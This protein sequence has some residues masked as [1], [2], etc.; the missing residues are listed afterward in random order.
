MFFLTLLA[1]PVHAATPATQPADPATIKLLI[2]TG[3]HTFSPTF[4]KQFDDMPGV[5]CTRAE[6]GDFKKGTA[7]AYDLAD[8]LSYDAVLLYDFQLNI[9]PDE[10]KHFLALF[11]KG[12]G[13]IVLHHALLS[14]QG[15]PEY[16]R[17]TGGLYLLDF[18]KYG[19]VLVPQSTYK[20]ETEMAITVVDK[21]HPVT[22]GVSDFHIT[23]EI[24]RGVHHPDDIHT[25]L[26]CEGNPLVWTRDE[27]NS[28]VV[29][30]IIGH[31]PGTW[32]NAS[33]Q[34]LLSNALHFVAKK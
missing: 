11:D 7:S 4:F 23:D 5:T 3:G 27:K 33:F 21:S 13:L 24:Y 10:Q 14:Y 12:T 15:W 20:G 16:E 29:S 17:I 19:E 8:L 6:E 22:A 2:V 31:G 1:F 9:T 28:H 32:N 34:K 25:L 26:S 30:F 18:K